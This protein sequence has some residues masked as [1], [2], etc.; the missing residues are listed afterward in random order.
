MH[1]SQASR[2]EFLK[3]TAVAGAAA[4][5]PYFWTTSGTR[6][7]DK[8]DRLNIGSIG[9]SIYTDRYT[10]AGDHPG[11]GAT[12]GHQAGQLGNMVAVADV[13]L[14]NARFF[15]K[16]YDGR[17]EIYQDYRKLLDRNDI[18]AVTIGTPDHW[19]VKIAIDAMRAGKDVYAEKPLTLTIDEGKKICKV[20]KETGRVLQVGTQQR[21][22]FDRMFLKAVVLARSG[23]LGGNLHALSSVGTGQSGGPFPNVDPP[24]EL[25]WDMWLGQTPKVPYCKQRGDYDFRWWLEYSGGQVTDWGVHHTD[26]AC[27]A[28][29]LDD[30]GPY[31]IEGT[32]DYPNTPN[33]YNT[34][35]TFDCS[36][37]FADNKSIRLYSG[38]NELILSGDRGRIRVN[39]G[40]LTGKPVEEL[41]AAD[42]DWMNDEILKLCHGKQP[43][44]H[45]QNFFD[46][47][48]DR[49][50]PISDVWSHH[51]AA[52]VCH[53]AN[54][55]MRLGRKLHWDPVKEDFVGDEEASRMLSRPQREPYAIKA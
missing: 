38:P 47:V 3:A 43:G 51:R 25:D 16:E 6:A 11:R 28:L 41:T 7:Q 53:L 23:R 19:H 5:V 24:A 34:A 20:V 37:K 52:S 2:R 39:R 27:W 13:N 54:I 49:G 10:G 31:E 9:T 42:D 45:M 18:D 21:S 26:I 30:T 35:V 17:C 8:N 40:G 48:K 55:A 44:S 36:M 22:E 1:T 33:G 50:K 32:G 4:A 14:R 46:C 12:I 29:N 15:A